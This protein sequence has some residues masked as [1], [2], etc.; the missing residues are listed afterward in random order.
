MPA[1][2]AIFI[3]QVFYTLA[4]SLQKYVLKGRG[5][6]WQTL[7]SVKFLLTLIPAGIGFIILM[8]ALS[9]MDISKTIILLGVFGVVLAAAS[10]VIFFH[11]KLSWVNYLGIAFAIAAIILVNIR[12]R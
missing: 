10:G 9:K 3:A 4:D 11:D 6:S 5:F 12:T 1:V 2:I 7:T 8:Y